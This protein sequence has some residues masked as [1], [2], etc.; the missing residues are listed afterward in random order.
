MRNFFFFG[1]LIKTMYD[2]EL[3]KWSNDENE[4][5]AHLVVRTISKCNL[6]IANLYNTFEQIKQYNFLKL[7]NFIKQF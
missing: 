3:M 1:I 7:F 4:Y 2:A 5:V 6:R